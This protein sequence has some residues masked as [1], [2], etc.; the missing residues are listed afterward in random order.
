MAD[1]NSFLNKIVQSK[2]K[3]VEREVSEDVDLDKIKE[4]V[5][6]APPPYDFYQALT[7]NQHLSLI[8]EIKRASPSKGVIRSDIDSASQ[9]RAYQD[10]GA[11]AISVLTEEDYFH[12]TI[13]DLIKAR[14]ACT[15]PILR[16]D[17][18][19]HP[20]QVYEA[21][22]YGADA[23]LLIAAVLSK[24]D[25]LEFV[26]LT[27]E[28]GMHPLVE[29]HSEEELP[30]AINS[31]TRIIG[32]N[33]R[34]LSTFRVDIETTARLAPSIP[35]DRILISESGIKGVDEAKQLCSWGVKGIL[36]GEALVTSPD[37][38]RLINEL[39]QLSIVC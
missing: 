25:L 36:V 11:S 18:I 13:E 35:K 30:N 8:A 1:Q 21:R 15:I 12:G 4:K 7:N 29:V 27:Y 33:N 32:I 39:T 9:A 17:F 20:Y 34:N 3:I 19:I 26:E 14:V 23:I 16:K 22:A 2:R 38:G 24:Q 10:F 28:L 5:K 31:G 37:L 6:K